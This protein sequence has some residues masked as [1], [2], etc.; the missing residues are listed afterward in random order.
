MLLLFIKTGSINTILLK[1]NSYIKE[2]SSL[3]YFLLDFSLVKREE[4]REL[5]REKT[6]NHLLFVS[7]YFFRKSTMGENSAQSLVQREKHGSAKSDVSK[8]LFP[9]TGKITNRFKTRI[10]FQ[11][12]SFFPDFSEF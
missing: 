7:Q 1:T 12:I 9:D 10:I 5:F 6:R 11:V 3:S 2:V 4:N 8:I